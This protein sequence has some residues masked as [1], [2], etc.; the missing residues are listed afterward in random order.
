MSF[1]F[2]EY[3]FLEKRKQGQ[4]EFFFALFYVLLKYHVQIQ[5][6]PFLFF[7]VFSDWG[8]FARPAFHPPVIFRQEVK[9]FLFEA[10]SPPLQRNSD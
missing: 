6:K 9:L 2:W 4:N 7:L 3:F 8:R 10:E 1:R 5:K